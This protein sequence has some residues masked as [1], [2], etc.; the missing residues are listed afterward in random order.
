MTFCVEDNLS[1]DISGRTTFSGLDG[2]A[3]LAS[4]DVVDG[5]GL[6][7]LGDSLP[8]DGDGGGGGDGRGAVGV[9]RG[10]AGAGR[11]A[12]SGA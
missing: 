3:K 9:T 8:A 10:A 1:L 5:V 12:E 4:D 11:G 2:E 6:R 7:S